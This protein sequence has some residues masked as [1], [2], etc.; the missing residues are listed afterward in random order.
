[1]T[2]ALLAALGSLLI[3]LLTCEAVEGLREH[4]HAPK[5]NGDG[6]CLGASLN[7]PNK[8]SSRVSGC[9]RGRR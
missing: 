7:I 4:N 1:M 9:S 2:L 3:E 5:G 8:L 6:G